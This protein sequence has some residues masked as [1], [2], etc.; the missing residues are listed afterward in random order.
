[1][2]PDRTGFTAGNSGLVLRALGAMKGPTQGL[3]WLGL[4]Y[5]KVSP[6]NRNWIGR[7]Q[8]RCRETM[9]CQS[10]GKGSSGSRTLQTY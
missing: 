8:R 4:N 10:G 1:M 6:M 7:G 5:E 2:E 3:T 9:A